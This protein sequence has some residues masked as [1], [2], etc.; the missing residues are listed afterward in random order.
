MDRRTLRPIGVFGG[1]AHYDVYI[2]EHRD[3]EKY[4]TKIISLSVEEI[5]VLQ[6]DLEESLRLIKGD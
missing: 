5:K 2:R 1:C 6:K 4:E 3:D